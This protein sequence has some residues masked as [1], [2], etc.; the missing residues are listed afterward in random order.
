MLTL[1]IGSCNDDPDYYTLDVPSDQMH[2]TAS[3]DNIVLERADETKEAI[4]FSWN[5]ATDRGADT[6]IVY[7]FRLYHSEMKAPNGNLLESE[8][9]KIDEGVQSI[10]W[11]VRELN[12]LLASWDVPAGDQ[13]TVVAE[14]LATVENST[15]Y[16]KPEI[17]ETKFNVVGYEIAN[18]LYLTIQ[19]GAQKRSLEM[20]TINESTFKWT[21]SLDVS[22]FWFVRNIEK[23]APAY[24]K[25]TSSNSLLYSA[26]GEG[27]HFKINNAGIYEILVDLNN[28]EI[29][30]TIPNNALY[31]VI[32]KG[33]VETVT[34][35][36]E[37][38]TGTDIYY[39]KQ[40]FE[41]GTKFRFSRDKTITWPA[42]VP[43]TDNTKLEL[44][45]L[46]ANMFEVTKAATYVMTVNMQ[47]N[48]L[49]FKD[50]Y[51]TSNPTGVIAVVGGILHDALLSNGGWDAGKAVQ[52]YPLTQTDLINKPEVIS[53]TAYM[54]YT[55]SGT[56]ENN[57]FKFVGNGN[58]GY[59][60]FAAAGS[61][62]N[63]FDQTKQD[64]SP[65]AGD[66][67]WMLPA[68]TVSGNYLLELNLHTMKI[69]LVKQ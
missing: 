60:L 54:T 27:E 12:N 61:Y 31:L 37:I 56:N 13:V 40:A 33:G 16:M 50:V 44:K 20:N 43:G 8:L 59:G 34:T 55:T 6:K 62:V 22:E 17:S 65:N 3:K 29:T 24:M 35:L 46:G 36:T 30:I 49:I 1:L 39:L 66:Q 15:E 42:Y 45:E 10:S 69:N 38:T 67:K 26:T 18:K 32:N 21:G 19:A 63:P 48:S 14:V 58:W 5:K 11:T 25:G 4:N 47:N 64:V 52:K 23:G 7:Y 9:I 53:V 28:M 57:A 41:V 68:G 2:V 51:V